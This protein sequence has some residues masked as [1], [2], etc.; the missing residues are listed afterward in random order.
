MWMVWRVFLLAA[1]LYV[2]HVVQLSNPPYALGWYVVSFPKVDDEVVWILGQRVSLFFIQF[3]DMCL[4]I[5]HFV[6]EFWY[7]E[8][9]N[10]KVTYCASGPSFLIYLIPSFE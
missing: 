6:S 9:W 8:S 5:H 10:T 3:G 4:P 7:C 1:I 2:V